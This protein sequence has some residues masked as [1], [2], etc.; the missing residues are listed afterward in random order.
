[1]ACTLGHPSISVSNLLAHIQKD[2]QLWYNLLRVSGGN[3][4]LEKCGYHV[5]FYKYDKH[6][7]PIMKIKVDGTVQLETSDGEKVTIKQKNIFQ[8]RKN[9][10]HYKAPS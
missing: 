3:L 8:A 7:Q 1:M 5:I 2:A 6:D 4:E 10:G 9:L